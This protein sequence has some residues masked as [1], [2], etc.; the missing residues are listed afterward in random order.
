MLLPGQSE[1]A[2][3]TGPSMPFAASR[4]PTAALSQ[5]NGRRR[6]QTSVGFNAYAAG[7]VESGACCERA[8]ALGGSSMLAF[9]LRHRANVT[10]TGSRSEIVMYLTLRGRRR[11]APVCGVSG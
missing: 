11:L 8:R 3:S 2:S 7:H 9:T 4:A 6:E 5:P 1:P 10:G